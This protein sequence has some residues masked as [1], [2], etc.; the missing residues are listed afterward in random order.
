MFHF[1]DL[2][3]F[4]FLKIGDFDHFLKK[5]KTLKSAVRTICRS[6]FPKRVMRFKQIR[7]ISVVPSSP[8]VVDVTFPCCVA[9][10]LRKW[11]S[12]EH[13]SRHFVDGA[14]RFSK[15]ES[16][17]SRLLCQEARGI[18]KHILSC[19]NANNSSITDSLHTD[20]IGSKSAENLAL[21]TKNSYI[22]KWPKIGQD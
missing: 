14:Q 13:G 11:S 7:S 6:R 22:L 9:Y 20:A 16:G 1:Q 10:S 8:V 15:A 5:K 4:K 3:N 17:G 21:R 2:T 19:N 18:Q 12:P